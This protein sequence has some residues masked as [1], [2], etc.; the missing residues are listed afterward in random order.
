MVKV[1]F[2]DIDGVLNDAFNIQRLMKDEP[3]LDHLEC[4]KAIIDLTG[5]EIVLTS[6]WRLFALSR[7]II[8][9]SLAKVGLTF[10]DRTKELLKGRTAEINEWLSRHQEVESFV[11]LDDDWTLLEDF[12]ENTVKT[13]F[14]KG[15]LPEHIEKAV[16]ILNGNIK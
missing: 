4:L 12:P 2:L 1:V 6:T 15:L 10:T 13:S 3:S 14:F 8:K 16:K 11:I 9:N 7:K 5:A